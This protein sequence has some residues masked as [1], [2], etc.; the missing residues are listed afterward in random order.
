SFF[1]DEQSIKPILLGYPTASE[2]RDRTKEA[3]QSRQFLSALNEK[4]LKGTAFEVAFRALNELLLSV[5]SFSPYD[6]SPRIQAVW[7]DF[8]M[9]KV[10][11]RIEGDRDKVE[12]VLEKLSDILT[13]QLSDIWSDEA[14]RPDLWRETEEMIACRSKAKIKWMQNRLNQ[15]G[16]TSFWP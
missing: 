14:K 11:P 5:H 4:A 13:V 3:D 6:D 7:D 16:F 2:V 10:L 9:M 1:N 8:L 12:Q 15:S